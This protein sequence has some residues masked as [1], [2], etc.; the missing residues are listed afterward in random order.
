MGLYFCNKSE[1]FVNVSHEKIYPSLSMLFLMTTTK[2]LSVSLWGTAHGL[3]K[4]NVFLAILKI[5][6]DQLC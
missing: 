1:K 4:A 6:L 3:V 5:D 2:W